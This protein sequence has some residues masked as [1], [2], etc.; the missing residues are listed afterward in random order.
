[1]ALDMPSSDNNVGS[2]WSVSPQSYGDGD[3]GSP[4]AVNPQ[5]EV[6]TLGLNNDPIVENAGFSASTLT[7]TRPNTTGELE[8]TISV[9][10]SSEL[11]AEFDTI[12]IS[13]GDSDGT[14]DLHAIDD[15]WDDGDQVVT[16]SVS[17]PGYTENSTTITVQDD[18]DVNTLIINEIYQGPDGNLGDANGDSVSPTFEDEFIEIVNVSGAPYDL[19]FCSI[20]ED[21][22]NFNG[23]VHVFPEGTILAPGAALVVFNGGAISDG[24]TS[25]FGTAEIQKASEGGLFLSDDGEDVRLRDAFE[26]ELYGVILPDVSAAGSSDSLTLSPDLAT[27]SPFVSHSTVP[28]TL[29]FSPGTEIDGVT[30]FVTITTPLGLTINTA[31]VAEEAGTAIGAITVSLPSNATADTIIRLESSNEDELT[32]QDTVTIPSGTSS[33]NVDVFPVDDVADDDDQIVTITA[34]LSGY[35]NASGDITVVDDEETFTDLVINEIDPNTPGTD[36]VEF[37]ELFNRTGSAQ[38]LDG[39]VVVLYNGS[40]DTAYD[41]IDLTGNTI[42]AGGFFVIG[43]ATVPNV[44]LVAFTS[45]SLQNGADAVALYAGNEADYINADSSTSS[46]TLLDS[47]VYGSSSDAGLIDDLANGQTQ[48]I[49]TGGPGGVE[50]DSMS[51]VPDGGASITLSLFTAE[52]ATPGETNVIPEESYTLWAA[53]QVPP[54][55]G[56]EVDTDLDGI[57]NLVEYALGLDPNVADGPPGSFIGGSLTFTKGD[58]AKDNENLIYEIETSTDLG[59]TDAWAVDGTAVDTTDDISIDLFTAGGAAGKFFGR[60]KVTE[61]LIVE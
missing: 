38:S 37:I 6:F 46:G 17:A 32:I 61:I 50:A 4:G 60:L 2:N 26:N 30:P 35:L 28:S 20:V 58:D 33:I 36:T 19:S 51:R 40:N 24:S 43:S 5:P 1:M 16:I 52:T 15:L 14:V 47:I 23:P 31:S 41:T 56:P 22:F 55:G 57:L 59:V 3:L 42:E 8:V 29:D 53:E 10:D 34:A 18:A 21:S 27:G 49:E 11:E 48:V 25:A 13:D 44:D 9:D 7:I 39:L 12:T 54:V 45:N